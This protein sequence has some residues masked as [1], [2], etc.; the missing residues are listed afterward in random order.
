MS[1]IIFQILIAA[2]IFITAQVGS[3]AQL[4][5]SLAWTVF[6]LVVIYTTPLILLQLLTIWGSYWVFSSAQR[7][8]DNG[9]STL[10][11]IINGR[12]GTVID[13]LSTHQ[14]VMRTLQPLRA[15]IYTE[16]LA[17]E[18]ALERAQQQ[19]HLNLR[20]A[21]GG[22]E[23]QAQYEQSCAHFTR[24]LKPAPSA[25]SPLVRLPDFDAIPPPENPQVAEILE[26]EIRTLREG[27]NQYLDMV[28]RTVCANAELKQLFERQ[29]RERNAVE[30]WVKEFSPL[31]RI[32]AAL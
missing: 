16:H 1:I 28:R 5:T 2:S 21:Q 20:F 17:V 13:Q 25:S 29:L 10:Q 8:T 6:T 15:A 3:R 7:Q 22:P 24:L 32:R 23:L 31:Q 12:V 18:K 30:V 4:L 11:A 14:V 26:Q 9:P 19:L 27:R